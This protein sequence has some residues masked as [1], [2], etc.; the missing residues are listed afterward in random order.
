MKPVRLWVGLVLLALGVF[1]ILDAV[2]VLDS[3]PVIANWWPAAVVVLGLVAMAAERR[4]SLGPV[5]IVVLGLVLLAGTLDWTTGNLL[6]PTVLAGVGVAVLVGLRRHHGTRTPVAMFGGAST[7]E[8]SKHLR[9]ADVSAIFGGATLDLREA[10]IDTDADVD[11]FA[12]FGGVDVLVPEGWRVSVG[13]L[14][15]MGGI[16]D[17]T[18]NDERELPDDAPVLTVNGTAL[19]GAVVVANRP[20]E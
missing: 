2:G 13:G 10:H 7:K 16:D 15:F 5:V 3:G 12:L 20:K 14:P 6:L 4:V 1:G 17:K 18:S 8:R 9:H 11:A 19:F